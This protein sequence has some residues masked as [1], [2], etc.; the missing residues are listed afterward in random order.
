M[1]VYGLLVVTAMFLFIGI[2]EAMKGGI[3]EGLTAWNVF[4]FWLVNLLV[5]SPIS[6]GASAVVLYF[7]KPKIMTA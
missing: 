6:L 3:P 2:S 4:Q 5:W 7:S 1:V